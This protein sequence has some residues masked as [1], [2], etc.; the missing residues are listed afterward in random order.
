MLTRMNPF[1]I[2]FFG[3]L[4]AMVAWGLTLMLG[5]LQSIL[6]II[7][8]SLFLALGLNPLVEAVVRRGLRRGLAVLLVA[9]SILGL[10][11]LAGWAVVP[12][13][14]EQITT[15]IGNAPNYLEGLRRNEQ[16][17]ELDRRF[18]II[19]K[20]TA[21]LNGGTML[22]Q[23]F[24]G[25]VGA[26]KLVA[27]VLFSTVVGLVLTIY[28]LASLPSIK[29]TI[30]RL[31][32][33]SR[34]PRVR[35]LADEMFRRIGGYLSGMF[36]VVTLA[37][38]CSFVFLMLAG[39]A[40]YALALAVLVAMCAFIPLVGQN[41]A[42]LLVAI[43]AFSTLGPW[44]GLAMIIYFQI[45]QQFDAYYVQPRVMRRSVDVPGPVVIVS[46]LA[47]GLLLGIVGAII[48]IP[49]AAIVLL[50]YREVLIPKLDRS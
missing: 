38:T 11:V 30:Y 1:A 5:Q 32:P 49:T 44:Y 4:G 9:L 8:V 23:I 12:V 50:L 46:A 25:L 45:Y 26:G 2:G 19:E 48:A 17:A 39:M 22:D 18:Q 3:T 10:L 41:I 20:A 37:G 28:F 40:K 13:F 31:A 43:V 15:L 27:N 14:T 6:I 35:Y 29:D 47:G 42:M 33:A 7:L 24:G 36:F 16:I 21:Y 34:R